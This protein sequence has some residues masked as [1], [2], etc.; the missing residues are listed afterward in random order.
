MI[1]AITSILG[2]LTAGVPHLLDFF[3]AK[4]DN[5]HE[6][7]M[8][9]L[10]AELAKIESA[11]KIQA[12]TI[13]YETSLADA[14][15]EMA[16]ADIKRKTG[17]QFIDGLNGSVRPVIAYAYFI[18]Y[19]FVKYAMLKAG[20]TWQLWT[21]EDTAIFAGIISFYYGNRAFQKVVK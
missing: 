5:A 14:Q 20:M 2:F 18:L 12:A 13:E 15:A 4:Q 17:I 3:K 19:A 6:L 1:A 9:R 7:E 10:Q 8:L 16:I 21:E 11:G